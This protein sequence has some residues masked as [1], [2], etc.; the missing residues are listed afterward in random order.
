MF[1]QLL[2]EVRVQFYHQWRRGERRG[3]KPG[4]NPPPQIFCCRKNFLSK[5][6]RSKN[7]KFGAKTHFEKI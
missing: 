4:S 3:S 5:N 7:V 6:V 2:G 1:G